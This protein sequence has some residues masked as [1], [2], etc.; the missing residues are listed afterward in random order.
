MNKNCLRKKIP[1][2]MQLPFGNRR[3]RNMSYVGHAGQGFSSKPHRLYG[4]QVL[5]RRQFRRRMPLTQYRQV[6]ILQ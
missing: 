6:L 4:L 2:T 3:N 1:I 5:K